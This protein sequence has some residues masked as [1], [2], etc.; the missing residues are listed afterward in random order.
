MEGATQESLFS[1]IMRGTHYPSMGYHLAN[2]PECRQEGPERVAARAGECTSTR[3]ELRWTTRQTIAACAWSAF[4]GLGCGYAW[5][6]LHLAGNAC[7]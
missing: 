5:L 1:T 4:F 6:F 7:R 3:E 2:Q